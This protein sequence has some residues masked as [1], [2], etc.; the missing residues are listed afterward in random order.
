[1]ITE[2][3]KRNGKTVKYDIK[4]IT[5]A[6][7]KAMIASNLSNMSEAKKYAEEVEKRLGEVSIIGVEK[8][9]DVVVEVLREHNILLA[10][11]Y[12]SYREERSLARRVVERMNIVDELKLP[13]NSL[14]ILESRYLLRDKNGNI[15]E[16]PKELFERVGK[17][18]GVIELCYDYISFKK[19]LGNGLRYFGELNIAKAEKVLN[20]IIAEAPPRDKNPLTFR[21][22]VSKYGGNAIS[23]SKKF[24][25]FMSK[26][27]FLPN[28]PTLMNAGLPNAQL[29]ACYLLGIEDNME[30]IFDIVKETA[31]IH[32]TGGGTGFNFSNLRPQ[33]DFVRSTQGVAS[34][35][36]SFMKIFDAVTEEIK[37]G[38]KRRGANMGMLKY[39]HPDILKFVTLKDSENTV[40][41]NFNVSVIVDEEFFTA[42]RNDGEI[43]LR[44]PHS[45][46]VGEIAGK[47]SA[48]KL[49]KE[50]AY[51]AWKSGDPGLFFVDTANRD[52]YLE[53]YG[54]I[55][56]TNPC[57]EVPMHPFE[58]CNLGSINLSKF[59]D[60]NGRFKEEEFKSVVRLA[61]RFL[62]D[63]IDANEM[64][65]ENVRRMNRIG[66]KIGLGVM[67][68]ADMLVLMKIKY[69]SLEALNMGEYVMKTLHEESYKMSEALAIE[70]YPFP[71]STEKIT[72]AK[73]NKYTAG[74][75]EIPRRN[76]TVQS[77]APTG[78]I[79]IIA[80]CSS[81][82]EPY[83]ALAYKRD[84][85]A[86]GVNGGL[87][88]LVEK[89]KYLERE[90]RERGIYSE[91]LINRI[92]ESGNLSN[93]KEI[94]EDLRELYVT[95]HEISPEWHIMMQAVFQNYC[96]SG[97]SKT[98]NMPNSATVEDVEKAYLMARELNCKGITIFRDG[99]KSTQVLKTLKKE[100]NLE[101]PL[102]IPLDPNVT[103]AHGTCEL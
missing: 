2:V 47:I 42:L 89:N 37:Q 34:G 88:T 63:V 20:N 61:V 48:K 32:K 59:V 9:Q 65:I 38:G 94:P 33:N 60:E 19:E 98:I 7:Y 72:T 11:I 73:G 82:I 85:D 49:F 70:K 102:E 55:E 29:S 96:D 62:D 15:I 52:N 71:N 58:S 92:A 35:P 51:N 46:E 75:I 56:G 39:D 28:T 24:I 44:N 64:G 74:K 50:I 31:L 21:E 30:S 80:D 10:N 26:L 87:H 83:F 86:M 23:Y 95:A 27:K 100:V 66:R 84:Y 91:S 12:S 69:D 79:S 57:G 77:I 4:K 6:I 41:R 81:S 16:T 90:L 67:G 22:Y 3:I 40:L 45:V 1:M 53:G 76:S 14:E 68:F 36:I 25:D 97:V 13:K 93:I 5:K 54:D 78:T 99:S 17:A 103:C 18:I 43:K 101:L 8:L